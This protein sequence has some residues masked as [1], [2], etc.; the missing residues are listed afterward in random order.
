[1]NE[2][3]HTKD[4]EEC[5][6]PGRFYYMSVIAVSNLLGVGKEAADAYSWRWGKVVMYFYLLCHPTLTFYALFDATKGY[7][8]LFKVN[9]IKQ[10]QQHQF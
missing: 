10:Q 2:K 1:M 9:K 4:L 7:G 3:I 8:G 5:E 6:V